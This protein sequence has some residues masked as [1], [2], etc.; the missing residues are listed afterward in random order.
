MSDSNEHP[1]IYER[2]SPAFLEQG[3]F[4]AAAFMDEDLPR[5]VYERISPASLDAAFL[6][7]VHRRRTI[8]MNSLSEGVMSEII[9]NTSNPFVKSSWT[10]LQMIKKCDDKVFFKVVQQFRREAP[11]ARR[12]DVNETNPK[13]HHETELRRRLAR[14]L[15]RYFDIRQRSCYVSSSF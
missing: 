3:R 10:I 1:K 5:L 12:D 9:K 4:S 7:C 8:I 11:F 13:C 14:L 6:F 15:D 2:F